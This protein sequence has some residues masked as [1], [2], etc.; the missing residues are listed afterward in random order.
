MYEVVRESIKEGREEAFAEGRAEGWTKGS[1][2]SREE[3]ARKALAEGATFDFVQKITGLEMET[4]QGF[5]N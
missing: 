2:A 1:E 3:V 5:K 4:I